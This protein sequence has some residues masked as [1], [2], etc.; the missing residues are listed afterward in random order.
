MQPDLRKISGPGADGRQRA[1]VMN[2]QVWMAVVA[3]A[4]MGVAFLNLT[5]VLPLLKQ[6]Y[7]A[8]N[9]AMGL[10]ITSLVLAHALI[11]P[12]AGLMTDRLGARWSLAA[13]LGICLLGSLLS[14]L[15][16]SYWFVLAMRVLTGVGTGILFVAGIR[17][18]TMHAPAGRQGQAQGYFGATINAGTIIPFFVSP[19]LIGLG[20]NAVFI[21]TAAF[22]LAPLIAVCLWGQDA[23]QP[24]RPAGTVRLRRLLGSRPVWALG[25]CHAV[26]FG[27]LMTIGTWIS[28]YLLQ[29]SESAAWLPSAGFLGAGVVA[30]GAL[31]RVLGGHLSTRF[32]PPATIWWAYF[33]LA[34]SYGLLG[35]VG[36]LGAALALFITANLMN[37]ITFSSVFLLASK[38]GPPELAGTATGLV[39]FI[40]SMGGMSIPIVFG[41]CIDLTGSFFW[42][43]CF[44]AAL[45]LAALIPAGALK[46]ISWREE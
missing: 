13:S 40:A 3:A 32:S 33:I 15:H 46:H 7:G 11:Q 10:L 19:Y 31:G 21:F 27:G 37:S 20:V 22:C 23:P 6:V 4:G 1:P 28:T 2:R 12:L 30:V 26:F 18:A 9:A 25:L 43:L 17:Y 29:F 39:N 14:C 41:Y 35:V 24:E 44:M 8:S 38:S 36:G 45:C 42:A 34:A 5:P 16:P